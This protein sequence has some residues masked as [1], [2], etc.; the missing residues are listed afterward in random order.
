M[1][2]DQLK[3][4]CFAPPAV[5]TPWKV[6]NGAANSAEF[7]FCYLALPWPEWCWGLIVRPSNGGAQ[8]RKA[9]PGSNEQ[10]F[11]VK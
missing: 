9:Y 4:R 5:S 1:Q 2:F 10:M 11:G 6:S 8:Q 3:R 7:N